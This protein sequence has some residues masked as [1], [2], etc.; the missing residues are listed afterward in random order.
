MS[1]AILQVHTNG[2]CRLRKCIVPLMGCAESVNED[3]EVVSFSPAIN[4]FS[5][6]ISSIANISEEDSASLR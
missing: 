1:L 3:S 4:A 5:L 2:E 6:F